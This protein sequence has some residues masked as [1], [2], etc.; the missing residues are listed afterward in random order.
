MARSKQPAQPESKALTADDLRLG[1]RKLQRRIADLTNFDVETIEERNDSKASALEDKVNS[2][3]ADIFGLDTPE[4]RK[5]SIWSFDTLPLIMNG[6]RYH[7][8]QIQ[9]A[10]TK[11]IKDAVIKLTGIREIL[12]EKLEDLTDENAGHS[13]AKMDRTP[14]GNKKIFIVHGHDELAKQTIAR[15]IT[16]LDL[17]PIILHEQPNQ[18]RTIIE[19]LE[20]HTSVDFAVVL[21]TPDDIGYSVADESNKSKRARQNVLLE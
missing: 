18:G 11:G 21:L 16:Q 17:T 5:S 6:P 2:T 9:E 12:E 1:I 15:F 19:K 10:Y 14:P 20:A 4:Y 8:T 13:H 3:L 7:V